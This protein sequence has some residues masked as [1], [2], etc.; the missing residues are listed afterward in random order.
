MP[1]TVKCACGSTLRAPDAMAGKKARCPQ[2][3][4]VLAVPE[5]PTMLLNDEVPLPKP[6]AAR[7]ASRAERMEQLNP[8][9][10]EKSDAPEQT[11]L[12]KQLSSDTQASNPGNVKVDFLFTFMNYPG[13]TLFMLALGALFLGLGIWNLTSAQAGKTGGGFLAAWVTTWG[14]CGWAWYVFSRLMIYGCA[15]PG[16]IVD[17][18]N[19][20]VAVITDLDC[21]IGEEHWTIKIVK[22]PLARMAGGP[23][24]DGARIGTVAGYMGDGSKG[25]WDTFEPHPVNCITR[26]LKRIRKVM[27]TFSERD[28]ALLQ[29]GLKEVPTPYKEGQWR[30]LEGMDT[31]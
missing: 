6:K 13:G 16:V 4:E 28:W 25:H 2:C 12:D 23:P 15:N 30:V 21:G 8:V 9:A 11:A 7:P 1:I 29:E 27:A 18:D 5:L 10:P 19:G 22:A 17:A 31:E 3:K 26:D 14:V 20:L 24:E